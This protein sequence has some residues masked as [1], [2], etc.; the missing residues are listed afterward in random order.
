VDS[1]A[2]KSNFLYRKYLVIL[3][4]LAQSIKTAKLVLKGKRTRSNR[5][6]GVNLTKTIKVM[7]Q[8]GKKRFFLCL[9]CSKIAFG[10]VYHE[11]ENNPVDYSW[12]AETKKS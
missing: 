11:S 8:D 5:K 1:K 12:S 3:D 10:V 2:T 6:K 7:A 9:S 4:E